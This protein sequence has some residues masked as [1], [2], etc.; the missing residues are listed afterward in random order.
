MADNQDH[1]PF[2][3]DPIKVLTALSIAVGTVIGGKQI[4]D[5]LIKRTPTR[6]VEYVIDASHAM[7]GSVGHEGKLSLV[8][9]NVVSIV[10]RRDDTAFA[11]RLAGGG[12]RQNRRKPQVS[13]GKDNGRRFEDALRRAPSGATNFAETVDRAVTDLNK[14]LDKGTESVSLFFV[15]AGKDDCTPGP[16]DAIVDSIGRLGKHRADLDFKFVGVRA[17]KPVHKMLTKIKNRL[18]GQFRVKVRYP[19]TPAAIRESLQP[20]P[21]KTDENPTGG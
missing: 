2:L 11:L 3:R 14:Q 16:A 10:N 17:P 5:E 7:E 15:V 8:R 12:C 19:K 1:T 4:Y 9:D 21:P 13:F 6:A 20:P 18:K